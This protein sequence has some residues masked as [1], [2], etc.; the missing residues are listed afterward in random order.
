MIPRR[1]AFPVTA[2]GIQYQATCP[3]TGLH[4]RLVISPCASTGWS[5][6]SSAL[7]NA[8][9][10]GLLAGFMLNGIVVLLS[11]QPG[12]GQ[13]V[14]YF[15]SAS[16]LF[17]AFVTLGLDSFLFGL[18][19]G[20][21]A[22]VACR[23]A[24]TEAM[25]AA[26]LLGVGTVA[27]VVS[28][29]FLLGVFFDPAIRQ[30]RSGKEAPEGSAG[31]SPGEAADEDLIR[32]SNDLLAML[33]S[34]LRPGVAL[35]VVGLLVMTAA[36]YLFAF[37]RAHAPTWAYI[38]VW[39]IWAIDY[40]VIG[41]FCLVYVW[42]VWV[43]RQNLM[44]SGT[45]QVQFVNYRLVGSAVNKILNAVLKLLRP[46]GVVSALRWAILLSV[47]YTVVSVGCAVAFVSI[48]VRDWNS[49]SFWIQAIVVFTIV[50]VLSGSLIPMAALLTPSFGPS[51]SPKQELPVTRADQL[52]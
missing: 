18:I 36:S 11:R 37:F 14:G 19:T 51:A 12:P 22:D 48:P 10:A 34:L 21:Q 44:Q 25:F 32:K 49:S 43:R 16:L 39:T 52:G 45:E 28:I 40:V 50:W 23:R 8:T 9:L 33:G 20:D 6:V 4:T 41:L 30:A 1:A 31:K 17:A 27:V 2:K 24:W 42:Y 5:A 13:R 35:L 15:Q 7:A 47:I 3:L 38:V 29:V 46:G 26:G